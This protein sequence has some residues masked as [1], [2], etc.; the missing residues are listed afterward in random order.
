MGAY[1]TRPPGLD[2]AIFT[3]ISTSRLPRRAQSEKLV[4]WLSDLKS[5]KI[6]QTRQPGASRYLVRKQLSQEI[7]RVQSSLSPSLSR[8]VAVDLANRFRETFTMSLP[9][10]DL[11][12]PVAYEELPSPLA[13]RKNNSLSDLFDTPNLSPSPEHPDLFDETN[14]NTWSSLEGLEFGSQPL[15]HDCR[16][17]HRFPADDSW[18]QPLLLG[19]CVL[20]RALTRLLDF[21][22]EFD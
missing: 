2:P 22:I 18:P 6:L 21:I 13:M 12:N 19:F 9:D 3:D 7:L 17:R 1:S 14:A 10:V 20:T 8:F 16:P 4:A 5:L 11:S 15:Q